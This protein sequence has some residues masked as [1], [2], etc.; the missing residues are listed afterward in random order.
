LA[1]LPLKAGRPP[2]RGCPD[3]ARLFAADLPRRQQLRRQRAFRRPRWIPGGESA[4]E[5]ASS[6]DPDASSWRI[7]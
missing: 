6:T 3:A 1:V 4:V 7:A 5:S 2:G